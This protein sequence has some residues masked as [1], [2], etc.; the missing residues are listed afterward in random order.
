MRTTTRIAARLLLGIAVAGAA[1]CGAG[2]TTGPAGGTEPPDAPGAPASVIGTYKLKLVNGGPLPALL[3][4]DETAAGIGAEMYIESGSIVL[5]A[6]STFRSTSVSS[7]IIEGVGDQ[8]QTSIN[9]GTYS[10]IPDPGTNPGE[11]VIW[12]RGENGGTDT[13][14]VSS[15]EGTLLAHAMIPG[16]VGQPDV[17]VT[18]F[19][20]R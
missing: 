4:Y 7:L 19:Y 12:V 15:V 3:W 8:V 11:G 14:L 10:F 16:A 9:D 13:L 17:E 2:E 5:R 20:S 1:A 6:D 18:S